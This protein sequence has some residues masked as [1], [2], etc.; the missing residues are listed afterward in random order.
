MWLQE[1]TLFIRHAV[2]LCQKQGTCCLSFL[3]LI[4][5]FLIKHQQSSCFNK[6]S[7]C[8]SFPPSSLQCKTLSEV[9]EHIVCVSSDP[10]VSQSAHLELVHLTNIKPSEGLVMTQFVCVH[11]EIGVV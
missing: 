5:N 4:S 2:S 7:L 11:T 6:D 10:L 3:V 1:E 8:F 9:C